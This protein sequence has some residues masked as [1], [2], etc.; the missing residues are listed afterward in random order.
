LARSPRANRG[1]DIDQFG[2][3]P[4][5]RFSLVRLTDDPNVGEATGVSVGA[6]IDAFGAISSIPDPNTPPDCG[7]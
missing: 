2:F 7:S 4:S 5:S 1:I 6:D 3:G